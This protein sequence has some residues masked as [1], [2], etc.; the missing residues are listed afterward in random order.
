MSRGVRSA[1]ALVA[2][3]PASHSSLRIGDGLVQPNPDGAQLRMAGVSWGTDFST[4]PQ[5]I[6]F[7]LPAIHGEAVVP[8]AVDLLVNGNP[9]QHMSVP[10]G[11]FTLERIHVP[12]GSRE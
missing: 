10:A 8:S 7:P 12:Q 9:V 2:D 6:T 3:F 1:S 11:P 4:T 5:F